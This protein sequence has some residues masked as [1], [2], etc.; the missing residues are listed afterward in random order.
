[1][2]VRTLLIPY[3][4]LLTMS[5]AAALLTSALPAKGSKGDGTDVLIVV[6]S[7]TGNTAAVASV[8]QE[9]VGGNLVELEKADTRRRACVSQSETRKQKKRGLRSR[10][11]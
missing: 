8:I 1:M 7:R 10:L 4:L 5:L 3:R 6:L 2:S 11:G 9:E